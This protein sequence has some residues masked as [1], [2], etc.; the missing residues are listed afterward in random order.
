MKIKVFI[1][2]LLAVILTAGCADIRRL[3][4]LKIE[5]VEVENISPRGLRGLQL[6]LSVTVDNPGAQI[7]LSEIYGV[8]EHSGKVLGEVAVVPFVIQGKQTG[9][10]TLNADLTLGKEATVLDLGRL[11]GKDALE[12]MT[13]D[14]SARLKI[15]KG[16]SRRIEIEDVPLKKLIDAVK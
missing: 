5:S 4:D 2:A 7:S 11:L 3:E 13:V 12:E 8:L 15:R 9:T 10:Y 1:A 16:P 6:T 14:A